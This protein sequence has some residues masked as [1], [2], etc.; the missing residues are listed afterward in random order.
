MGESLDPLSFSPLGNRPQFQS[1][2]A[3]QLTNLIAFTLREFLGGWAQEMNALPDFSNHGICNPLLLT[4]QAPPSSFASSE[5][6]SEKAPL[7]FTESGVRLLH[8]GKTIDISLKPAVQQPTLLKSENDLLAF[9]VP[10]ADGSQ[11]LFVETGGALTNSDGVER[12][13]SQSQRIIFQT[14]PDRFHE[15]NRQT[16]Q[17]RE[18]ARP[19]DRRVVEEADNTIKAATTS[20]PYSPPV[21]L[22]APQSYYIAP[23]V[24]YNPYPFAASR[25]DVAK[26]NLIQQL[27]F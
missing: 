20:A 2:Q 16:G 1:Q 19:A 8:Q 3:Q 11:R 4:E 21:M 17:V 24:V 7:Q 14:G 9:V 27:Q 13:L 12:Q 23:P 26:A 15:V 5:N 22:S 18:V 10:E 6:R 25:S